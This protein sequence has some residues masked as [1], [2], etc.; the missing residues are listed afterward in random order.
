MNKLTALL[1][2]S[3]LAFPAAASARSADQDRPSVTR[4]TVVT[5]NGQHNA[6]RA[7]P[8]GVVKRTT[9]ATQHHNTRS[10]T[11]FAK[12]QKFDRNRAVSYQVVDYRTNRAKLHRPPSGYN[13]VRSGRDVYLIKRSNGLIA[14]V[15]LGIFR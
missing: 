6:P 2:A 7:T 10:T 4:T 1:L 3:A 14:H 9:V 8:V 12:G 11:R 5:T 15:A 13:W